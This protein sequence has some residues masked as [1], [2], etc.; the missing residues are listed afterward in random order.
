MK[1]KSYLQ[2]YSADFEDATAS[3]AS[4][5]GTS[6]I[7]ASANDSN[8]LIVQSTKVPSVDLNN[9]A[10]TEV[11]LANLVLDKNG[12]IIRWNSN[13]KTWILLDEASGLW[14][15][16]GTERILSLIMAELEDIRDTESILI[17]KSGVSRSKAL[18]QIEKA[19]SRKFLTGVEGLMRCEPAIQ[20]QPNIFDADP[21]LLGLKD[22]Q[23]YDLKKCMVRDIYADDYLTKAVNTSF[24]SEATCPVW[25]KS[26][27]QWCRN[28]LELV[29]FLQKWCGYS[30]SGLTE[31]QKFLF[32]HGGGKNGKSVFLKV[33]ATLS[34]PY[35][36]NLRAESLMFQNRSTGASP[37]I[38]KLPGVRLIT[39]TELP[40]GGRFDENL[41]KQLTGGD[42]VTARHL[43]QSEFNFTPQL[44][45]VI[46]GN[47]KPV[48]TGT[49]NGFWRRFLL[50]P[51]EADIKRID[52]QLTAKLVDELP[53]ILNWCLEGWKSYQTEGLDSPKVV[54]DASDE[55]RDE[56]DLLLQWKNDCLV[57]K[58]EEK[59]SA[60]RAYAEYREWAKANGYQPL[61]GNSFSRKI[62]TYLG[63]SL[64]SSDGKYYIGYEIKSYFFNY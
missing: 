25:E 12:S 31:F 47:H 48:V 23:C 7:P 51:F 14:H 60:S 21:Y 22:G 29:S 9:E 39:S 34:G 53:G 61:S 18:K 44:K 13:Q 58:S 2:D 57:E 19:E 4:Y 45:L 43:Y 54:S 64:R 32:L 11:L 24:D 27:Y 62:K 6:E 41:L 35:S 46:A 63:P 38:A 55:Y 30:L 15:H 28:D 52:P 5:L 42:V 37:D 56:M 16:S 17:K 36:S 40:E 49:D 20:V 8:Y 26:I 1:T 3:L 59:I 50:I 33:I 10:M